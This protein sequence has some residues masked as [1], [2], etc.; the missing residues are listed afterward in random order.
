MRYHWVE[1]SS[2]QRLSGADDEKCGVMG[3]LLHQQL[4]YLTEDVHTLLCLSPK[5]QSHLCF[6]NRLS[7]KKKVK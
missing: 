1:T 5:I 2:D 6:V 7:H 4:L 3:E